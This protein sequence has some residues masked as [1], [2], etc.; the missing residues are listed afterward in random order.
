MPPSSL[1]HTY[2]RQ[3]Q[4]KFDAWGATE[5]TYRITLETLLLGLSNQITVTNEHERIVWVGMP[6]FTIKSKKD[7]TIPLWRIEAKDL[8]ISL[9]ESKNTDQLKRYKDA[10]DNFIYTNYLSFV[11]YRNGKKIETVHLGE[12]TKTWIIRKTDNLFE[13]NCKKLETLLKEFLSFQGITITSP[14]KL[15]KAMA[16]KAQ[17]IKFAIQSIFEQEENSTLELQ[18]QAFKSLLVHDLTK[19]Q[20]ADMYAQTVAYGLFSARLYDPTLP[21]F[22]R[23]EAEKLIPKSTPFIRWLFKQMS[24]DDEFDERIAYIIDDLVNIFLHCDVAE[25]LKNYGKKTKLED[26][27]IHFYETFLGEYDSAM[28]K[29]R[30]VYYTPE[31]VVKF[32]VRGVDYLLK[33]EFGLT[34]WLADTTKVEKEFRTTTKDHKGNEST[35]KEKRA[36][37]RVQILDP[38]TWTGTFLHEVVQY[39]YTHYFHG[40]QGLWHSYVS[41]DLLPRIRWFEILMASYTMAHLKLW[42]TLSETGRHG[43]ERVNIYLTNSL[44]EPHDNLGTLFSQALAKESEEASKVKREQPIMVVMGNPP[45]SVSSSNKGEWIQNLIKDY[46]KWLN[47]KKL[48]LDDDYV[49][50]IRYAEYF[51]EKN[52]EGILA[53]ITNNNYLDAVTFRQMRKKLS[54]TFNKIYIIDLHWSSKKKEKALDGSKD[55][56]VF[57]I[58]QGVSIVFWVKNSMSKNNRQILHCHFY[59]TRES[60]YKKLLENEIS[61][62]QWTSIEHKE[63]YNFF[64]PKDFSNLK[65]YN[66]WIKAN[67]IFMEMWTWVKTDRDNLFIDTNENVLKNRIITLLSWKLSNDFVNDYRVFNSWSYKFLQKIERKKFENHFIKTI[68]Y[69]P[70]DERYIY[71][72][73]SIVS[74]AWYQINRHMLYWINIALLVKRQTKF[75]FSYSFVVKSLCESCTFESAYANNSVLPLYLYNDDWTQ[76]KANLSQP[77]ID[78]IVKN[79]WSTRTP[80]GQGDGN[81]LVWPEDIFNYIYAVLHSPTYRETYKEFLKTDFPR[82]PFTDKVETFWQLVKLWYQLRTLHLMEGIERSNLTTTY[83]IE[84]TNTITKINKDSF[85]EK[86]VYINETQC[87]AGVSEIARTFRIGGYQP[88]QKRLKDRQGETLS[89]EDIIHYQ[90]I[91]YILDKTNEIMHQIDQIQFLP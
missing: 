81:T 8:H 40:Q 45:Y 78:E 73:A 46:K 53:F 71:Y 76:R 30:G 31:P 34:D 3:I 7:T 91:V 16:Q 6:D 82:V 19:S 11:F 86:R 67:D 64:V 49:K 48:N 54:E 88:A 36:V 29:K 9:D 80:D 84:W 55:E 13:D 18:Y 72:D 24:N 69:R 56:N 68:I 62:I 14:E 35:K 2:I 17:L 38:A 26:P 52:K 10:F 37:H 25:I 79:L 51:I 60:K 57:D 75:D 85:R 77:L 47:E 22:S 27:I 87:F 23:E 15:A 58:Q 59:W 83:P 61:H 4:S 89:Y 65:D 50:F 32:I 70:F 39:I 21:T 33:T 12:R 43:D 63:P 28:R 44:E 42:L 1:I 5:H 74:R 66:K 41:N 90:K 20:F